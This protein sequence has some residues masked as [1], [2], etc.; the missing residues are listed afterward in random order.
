MKVDHVSANIRFSK[1]TG[2]GWKSIELGVE[3][4]LDAE[5]DWYLAQQGLYA[6]LTVQLRELWGKSGVATEPTQNGYHESVEN[7]TEVEEPVPK[8]RCSLARAP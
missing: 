6:M 8:L 4:G 2:Q 1:D 3:A 5:E 7:S